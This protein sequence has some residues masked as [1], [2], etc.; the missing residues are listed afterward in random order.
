LGR[1][2]RA[3]SHFVKVI[4]RYELRLNDFKT[5]ICHGIDFA[6][7][8]FHRH[9]DVLQGSIGRAFVELF[10]EILYKISKET[11][12]TNVIGYALRRFAKK[13]AGSSEKALVREYLQRLLF[14][15]P[16]QARWIFPILLE[17]YR[18]STQGPDADRIIKWG[19]EICTRR[20]DVGSLV[21]FLYAALFM[22]IRLTKTW[23][24]MCINMS[25][26]LVDLMLFHGRS[27]GVFLF[28][29]DR[30]RQRYSTSVF[31]E[32]AWLPLYEVERRGWDR[33][34]AFMKIGLGSDQDGLYEQL[35]QAGVE[36]YVT[37]REMFEV[38]AFCRVAT[39]RNRFY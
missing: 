12:D 10:F 18:Y 19:V 4:S 22:R 31:N 1:R 28:E 7:A 36:F 39:V 38:P 16:F 27:E 9:F 3:Q 5:S 26:E 17:I 6:P 2:K 25:N 33:T 29:I 30:L 15:A 35:L 20:N 23:C 11:L 37:D 14:A 32:A 34:A 24:E 8:N 13:L 21:W